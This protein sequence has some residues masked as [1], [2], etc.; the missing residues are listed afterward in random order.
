MCAQ[1]SEARVLVLASLKSVDLLNIM[2]SVQNTAGI[3]CQHHGK[4]FHHLFLRNIQTC[5]PMCICLIGTK[6]NR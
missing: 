6:L 3:K 5:T 4:I 1:A 2:Q